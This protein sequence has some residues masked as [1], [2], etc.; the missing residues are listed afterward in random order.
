MAVT[1][2]ATP[3]GAAALDALRTVV[4][5]AKAAD[6]MASVTLLLPNNLT[7]IVARRHLAGGLSVGRSGVAGLHLLTLPR[8]AEQLG[9][10]GLAPRRPATGP[11]VA[12]AWRAALGGGPS[13]FESVQDHPATIRAI[14]A[15][16]RELRDLSDVA[17]AAVARSS[18]LTADLVRLHRQ[19][20]G[21]LADGWYDATDLLT[22]A[23]AEV[24]TRLPAVVALG[25]LVLFLPQDLTL[26]ESR[27]AA[28]LG[29]AAHLTIL[30][31]TTD[32]DR[33]DRAVLRSLDRMGCP[34]DRVKGKARVAREVVHA[35]DSDDEIRCL[36]RD[37][38]TTLETTPAHRVAV[39][40]G[41]AQPYARLLHEHLAAARITVNGAGTRPVLERAIGRGFLDVLLLAENDVPRADLFTAASEAPMRAFDGARIPTS[42]WERLSRSAAVV[43]GD[44]WSERLG[45]HADAL[46][47]DI[48]A[49]EAREDRLPS[50]LDSYRRDL[51]TICA[52]RAFA[53]TLRDRLR[54][55]RSLTT[56]PE[57]SSWAGRLFRDLFGDASAL[58][59]LP[60]DEQYAAVTLESCLR[61]LADLDAFERHADLSGLIGVLT[62]ELESALPRIGRFGEGVL[63]APMSAAIG[64]DVDV[65]YAV[66]LAEDSYPG[67]LRE[68]ALLLERVRDATDGE[69]AS[70]RDRLD[71]KHRHLLAAFDAAA[72]VV[73]SF[74]RGD[75]RRSTGRLPSRWILP[76]LRDLAGDRTLAATEWESVSANG[77]TGSPSYAASLTRTPMPA[78][79]QEWRTKAAAQGRGL[80]D[81]TIDAAL[82]LLRARS[83]DAFTRFDGNLEAVDGLPDYAD[84][85]RLVA[86]TTLERYA[87]CPHA[88]FVQRLLHVEPVEQPEEIISISPLDVGN[89]IH[90]TMDA[91]V[92]EYDG[93]LPDF[94]RP[95]TA[96]QGARLREIA[97][98]VAADFERSGSTGH[99]ALW[100]TE[101][102][103]I[104]ADLDF[105]LVDDN[106]RRAERDSRVLRSELT[107]GRD[108][109]P[110]VEVAVADGMVRMRGSADLVEEARDGTLVVIDIKTGSSTSFHPIKTDAVV[111]GTKLQ[112]PVY[113]EAARQLLGG[114]R[115]E[116]AYWFVRRDKH[117][118]I[119]L[120]LTEELANVYAAAVGTLV[121]SI[122][123]GRFPA[124]AP[125]QPDFAWVQCP[126]CN[127][128]GL[129]HGDV[130]VRWERKR[131]APEL[132][133]LVELIDPGALDE[134]TAMVSG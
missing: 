55:G 116:A 52:L 127:P 126:Y 8:L 95:W 129:G 14:V 3:Y 27:F 20:V 35:S 50:R 101:R 64:L 84:G 60:P 46:E 94:G 34:L 80:D 16:H 58:A 99:R 37:V 67:R 119:D 70:Y 15:A 134:P 22:A 71:A 92:T 6:P 19:V 30:V 76:T 53:T 121:S 23:T 10:A 25:E 36:V 105:M 56:W 47:A 62:L 40:Y 81:E 5:D 68:D 114:S 104:L 65:V 45:A 122:K 32:V 77:L 33:A 133:E 4:H 28:A 115:A 109:A 131:Q 72:R 128:D 12:A 79:K 57:L 44:D 75:L 125:D 61:Q 89:L 86:P 13:V 29:E 59:Q 43:S 85:R 91:F 63:V 54:E 82:E 41:S 102:D 7:G 78:T 2:I 21:L 49:E 130:R 24:A 87:G 38:V 26:G 66:G 110:P 18:E 90:Q 1:T 9:A 96:E 106:V 11:I 83:S 98:E 103:R 120:A 100:Q 74:P 124:K 97:V 118:W 73:V 113:A 112:L 69:L 51:D 17:L 111:G 93:A 42:R 123:A 48:A 117:G 88:F 108:G 107:F 132:R 39:L 31:G